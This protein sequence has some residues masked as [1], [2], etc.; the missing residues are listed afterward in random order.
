MDKNRGVGR[1]YRI[2]VADDEDIIRQGIQC[3]FDYEALGFTIAAEASNADQAYEAILRIQPDVVLMDI[4]MPGMSG[5][6]VVRLAREAGYSG[7]VV[8]ISSYTDF[9]YAQEAIRYGVQHY[10]TKPIDEDE[11]QA[12]LIGFKEE[13]D[14]AK[15]N[16]EADRQQRLMAHEHIVREL[17]LSK[18]VLSQAE[19]ESNGLLAECY[20]VVICEN[21]ASP[22]QVPDTDTL[23]HMYN[24]D[25]Q[26]Y[27]AATID[28]TRVLLLK[29]SHAL[30]KF[31]K[32]V[33]TGP[34][35]L[36]P[37][38]REVL[39]AV[40]MTY[41]SCVSSLEEAV[42]SYNQ[43]LQCL[44]RRF[45]CQPGQQILGY[46]QLPSLR[47]TT[48]VLSDALC[49]Q[50]ALTLLNCIQSFN[51]TLTAQTLEALQQQLSAAPDSV[52]TIKLFLAD[53]FLRIKSRMNHLHPDSGMPFPS[54]ADIIRC[55]QSKHFLYEILRFFTSQF[56]GIMGA[57]GIS[58]RDSILDDILQYIN[59]NY[60]GNI[61]L[62][63]IAPL[64]GYNSSY[65]G[66]IFSKK[67]GINFNA[68]VD[69]VRIE[70]AKQLLLDEKIKVYTI[71]E[72]V[73]YRNV[74]YFHIKFRKYVGQSPSEYRK[75]HKEGEETAPV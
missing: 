19:Q 44:G 73:G 68:Y 63:S 21:L 49:D 1:V 11:L 62:E 8:I 65:L 16:R 46:G 52:E 70:H 41:G 27:S 24:S 38:R 2:L 34:E 66:K 71:A 26:S 69:Q 18:T 39:D 3:F 28:G 48:P 23:L 51:R 25:N 55:I 20:Q 72:R 4:R 15:T 12:I 9:R 42:A 75:A 35:D 67:V 33:D 47:S 61:T 31:G 14:Q 37:Q 22:D 50:Y 58:S 54:N 13:F 40:F 32:L 10:L 56:E 30:R 36:S 64:F 29:G 43:A 6:E 59:H 53:L 5:L 17:L 45:F 7:K 57:I 74:D 60:T